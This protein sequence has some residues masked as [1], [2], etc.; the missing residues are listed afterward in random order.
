M[1]T[2]AFAQVK[3]SPEFRSLVARRWTVSLVL[4]ALMLLVYYG[5]VMVLA[6]NK[7][8]L[9]SKIGEHM[10]L[11]IPVGVGIIL[12]AWVLTGVY[13]AWANS[14]YDTAVGALKRRL[15]V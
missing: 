10:T 12:L 4:T 1:S 3:D 2:P 14:S 11:G 13:V 6:F 7:G 5:F 8:L 9:A 15:R